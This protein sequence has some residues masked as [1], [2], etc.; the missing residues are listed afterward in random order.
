M[1]LKNMKN[2]RQKRSAAEIDISLKIVRRPVL[3]LWVDLLNDYLPH[4]GLRINYCEKFRFAKN[5]IT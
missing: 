1:G 5:K 2:S 3:V 4:D